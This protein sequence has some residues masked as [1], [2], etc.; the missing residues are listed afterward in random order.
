MANEEKAIALAR[1]VLDQSNARLGDEQPNQQATYAAL[2]KRLGDQ[3]FVLAE[4]IIEHGTDPTTLPAVIAEGARRY[5]VLEGN[6]RILTLK[7]LETPKIIEGNL[8]AGRR[9]RWQ[10][11]ADEYAANPVNKMRCIVFD[12]EDSARHWI[13][14]RHTGANDGA[15]LVE[16]DSN[17]KD[18][19][20][21]RHGGSNQR[22]TAGQ[23]IDFVERIDP[24]RADASNRY[25]TTLQRLVNTPE[26]RDA[27]GIETR[28]GTVLS[29]F[30]GVEVAKGLQKVVND[31]RY[32]ERGVTDL[33]YKPGRLSYI[34]NFDSFQLPTEELRL[35]E[36]VPLGA[37]QIA[38]DTPAANPDPDTDQDTSPSRN[39]NHNFDDP[40]SAPQ[41]GSKTDAGAA[42][43]NANEVDPPGTA[44]RSSRVKPPRARAKV[45]PRSCVLH[46]TNGRINAI[47]FE[48]RTLDVEDYA[49]A[50]SVLLRVFVEL[51]TDS[52][53]SHHRVMPDDALRGATLAKKL[54]TASDTLRKRDKITLQLERAVQRIADSVGPIA[55]TTINFNQFVHNEHVFPRSSE[56]LTS[57][58]ELEPYIKALWSD[59]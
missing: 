17:E 29:W 50:C 58:D 37:L 3:I 36:A 53:I 16:W 21:S 51:S 23:I 18:R 55:A 45:I 32:G 2:A 30:P 4:D 26:V 25:I 35:T 38:L 14:I 22:A 12:S 43:Q 20:Q 9:R 1:L 11:L 24:P 34:A 6:R 33:Y 42:Q 19:Y 8:T 27:L 47:Y 13:E 52:Y 15:G 31:L 46:I 10:A 41:P 7:A 54:K 40:S 56:L 5:R 48:L 44:A 49:N 57:W 59:Q 28:K 39:S